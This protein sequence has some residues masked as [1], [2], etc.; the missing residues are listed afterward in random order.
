M[1]V[2]AQHGQ[3]ATALSL[4]DWMR[5]PGEEGGG[6]LTPSV[7]TYTAAMRAAL[8]GSMM[9]RA[10]QVGAAPGSAGLLP[11]AAPGCCRQAVR[12][13]AGRV[14]AVP[15]CPLRRRLP[16]RPPPCLAGAA[17]TPSCRCCRPPD[18]LQVWEDA[19]AAKCEVDCRLCTTLIEVCGRKGDTDRALAAYAQVSP[20]RGAG[21]VGGRPGV[22]DAAAVAT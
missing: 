8:T 3:A 6:G 17:L 19:L 10:L 1:R 14:A 22:D 16:L 21:R 15:P 5:T 18:V 13:A 20:C 2:C 12:A 7:F 9:D 11:P 4:Y